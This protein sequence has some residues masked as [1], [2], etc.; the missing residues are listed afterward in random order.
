MGKKRPTKKNTK[1][2]SKNPTKKKKKVTF[3]TNRKIN[4][5]D[6]IRV[7]ER[8]KINKF[9]ETGK[10]VKDGKLR[11]V[12]YSIDGNIGYHYYKKL[13]KRG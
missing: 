12:Y 7:S 8:S 13:K 2:T 4:P 1:P 11:W 9:I 3:S 5:N 6:Y 10:Q